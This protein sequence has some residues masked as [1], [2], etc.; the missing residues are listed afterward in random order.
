MLKHLNIFNNNATNAKVEIHFPPLLPL[1]LLKCK[2]QKQL[3]LATAWEELICHRSPVSTGLTFTAVIIINQIKERIVRIRVLIPAWPWPSSPQLPSSVV[4]AC[5][6]QKLWLGQPRISWSWWSPPLKIKPPAVWSTPHHRPLVVT[7]RTAVWN[8]I[9]HLQIQRWGFKG[10]FQVN[11]GWFSSVLQANNNNNNRTEQ[12][13]DHYTQPRPLS[14][15]LAIIGEAVFISGTLLATLWDSRS[16]T[17]GVGDPGDLRSA[18][19]LSNSR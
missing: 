15:G 12:S 5:P 19:S 8:C 13:K 17:R 10:G 4:G 3:K 11:P 18:V 1:Y 6:C 9:W 14:G 2:F 16:G 7:N